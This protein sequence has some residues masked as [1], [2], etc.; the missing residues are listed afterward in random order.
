[1]MVESVELRISSNFSSN[2]QL[3]CGEFNRIFSSN[4]ITVG[5]LKSDNLDVQQLLPSV[6]R[7]TF[8]SANNIH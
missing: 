3:A 7:N 1:M 4:A 8:G 6:E 5:L 2:G